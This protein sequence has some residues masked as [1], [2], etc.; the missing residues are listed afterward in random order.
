VSQADIDGEP[1]VGSTVEIEGTE[2]DG[3]NLTEQV[4][5]EN[6]NDEENEDD[7]E[8]TGKATAIS[9]TLDDFAASANIRDELKIKSGKSFQV[10]LGSNASTGYS[11]SEAAVI[12]DNTIVS[13]IKHEFTESEDSSVVGAPGEEV[14]TFEAL[15]KGVTTI[16]MTYARPWEAD[17]AIWTFTLDVTVN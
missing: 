11:W 5:I 16:S 13:Q 2:Q 1:V 10:A 9:F 3:V 4:E 15:A 17:S 14:W 8:D 6:E 7:D 12:G